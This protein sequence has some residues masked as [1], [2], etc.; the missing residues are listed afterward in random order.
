MFY[1]SLRFSP[2]PWRRAD[3]VEPDGSS[4]V[5]DRDGRRCG[6]RLDKKPDPS[7]KNHELAIA[8]P[9][10]YFAL[11]ALKAAVLEA[12]KTNVPEE[13]LGRI[14][15]QF[16]EANDDAELALS[17]V[18]DVDRPDPA[19][20]LDLEASDRRE[21]AAAFAKKVDAECKADAGALA[22][23]PPTDAELRSALE[24]AIHFALNPGPDSEVEIRK[25]E[26]VL[27]RP[28]RE[29]VLRDPEK[30]LS[31][32]PTPLELLAGELVDCLRGVLVWARVYAKLY[33]EFIPPEARPA[34][35]NPAVAIAAA[36]ETLRKI[37]VEDF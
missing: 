13:L 19:E 31:L 32:T 11:R 37:E 21:Y 6:I 10:L 17:L 9:Y 23:D 35:K 26:E 12:R 25:L 7:K 8:A 2:F 36:E 3:R 29:T 28:A 4:Q 20:R 1:P 16:D 15:R 14:A 18:D 27:R 34:R 24:S 5:V 30:R 33:A 22:G